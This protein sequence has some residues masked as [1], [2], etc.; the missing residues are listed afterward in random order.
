ML[1]IT[2]DLPEYPQRIDDTFVELPKNSD[3]YAQIPRCKP[4]ATYTEEL[5]IPN[6]IL[7]YIKPKSNKIYGHINYLS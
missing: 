7:A 4:I 2:L 3:R 1:H 5:D 6:D